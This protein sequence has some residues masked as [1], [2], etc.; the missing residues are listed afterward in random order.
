MKNKKHIGIEIFPAEKSCEQGCSI[1]PLALKGRKVTATEIDE[2]VQKTFSLIEEHLYK[3]GI[4]YDMHFGA[5]FHL[6]PRLHHPELIHMSRFTTSKDIRLPNRPHQFSE[7]IR[8]TLE[9]NRIDPKVIDF[10]IVPEAPAVSEV[11]A[12]LISDVLDQIT[13]WYFES[14][15]RKVQ[16]TVRT[17]ML[18][19]DRFEQA[20]PELLEKDEHFLRKIVEDRSTLHRFMKNHDKHIVEYLVARLYGNFY[21]GKQK[22]NRIYISNRVI[23]LKKTGDIPDFILKQGMK[24]YP[25]KT[26]YVHFALAPKGVMLT[27]ESAAINNPIRWVSHDDFRK[28][29]Q[30]DS[31]LY[32]PRYFILRFQQR[33]IRENALMHD[34]IQNHTSPGVKL[35]LEEYMASFAQS[36]KEIRPLIYSR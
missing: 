17:N 24:G 13:N 9:Q 35:N 28:T 31:K 26:S 10:S 1:C 27:H 19:M 29:L 11:D 3:N 20:L 36:R 30:E 16:V 33:I 2:D 32:T 22:T 4:T 15:Y 12:Y 23:G 18:L 7:N 8:Q 25:R 34:L 6:F 21:E 5:A 14:K